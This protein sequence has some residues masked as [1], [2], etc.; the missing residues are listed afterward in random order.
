MLPYYALFVGALLLEMLVID[1]PEDDADTATPD[2]VDT[3]PGPVH[4]LYDPQQYDAVMQGSEGADSF[5]FE[6]EDLIDRAFLLLG[7]NDSVVAGGGNDYM[8]GGAG[9]DLL[10]G[11]VGGD[12]MLGGLGDDTLLGGEGTD[13]LLGG[14]GDDRV[15]GGGGADLVEGSDGADVI[16]GGSGADSLAGGAGDDWIA[17]HALDSAVDGGTVDQMLGGAGD[18]HLL[19]G[20]NDLVN[21]GDG[22]DQMIVDLHQGIDGGPATISDYDPGTGDRIEFYVTPGTDPQTGAPVL[23]SVSAAMNEAGTATLVSLDGVHMLT[24]EGAAQIDASAIHVI[25]E[26]PEP[27]AAR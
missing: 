8:D 15:T 24:I 11:R 27:F 21:G 23:P 14:A 16:D 10:N 4:P 17:G 26:L 19:I 20:G 2:P 6:N 22:A 3:T 7:G 18:D 25:T 1:P 9:D 13:R 12:L 5:G